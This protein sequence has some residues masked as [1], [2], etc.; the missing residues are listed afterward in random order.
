[1]NIYIY[2]L[3]FMFVLE[4]LGSARYSDGTILVKQ[5][6]LNS[7]SIFMK[8][9]C[10]SLFLFSALRYFVG[11][12]Y[13]AYFNTIFHRWNSISFMTNYEYLSQFLIR[14]SQ[15]LNSPQFFFIINAGIVMYL[16]Y[17]TTW[18]YSKDPW[19]SLILFLTFPLF[20]LNSLSVV[21]NFTAVMIIYYAQRYIKNEEFFKYLIAVIIATLF[22]TSAIIALI[23]YFLKDIRIKPYH[24][25]LALIF[26]PL[27]RILIE[28]MVYTFVPRFSGYLEAVDHH[29]GTRAIYFFVIIQIISVLFYKYLEK[30]NFDNIS[31]NIYFFGV[32]LYL[33]FANQGTVG[34]RLSLYGTIFSLIVIPDLV[35]IFKKKSDYVILK[36]LFYIFCTIIYIYMLQISAEGYIPYQIFIGK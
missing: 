32:L 8:I 2:L 31:Y 5:N 15:I 24:Q 23:F 20:Y 22:H 18:Q 34:H 7:K 11:W 29:V 28:F 26:A 1:M 10:L 4:F 25:M 27:V 9:A 17:R 14:I 16:F 6:K 33:M 12:D 13:R 3:V 36:T 30:S 21:R 19:I 35:S